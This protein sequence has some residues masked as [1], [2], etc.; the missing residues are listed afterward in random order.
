[1]SVSVSFQQ[2][3][4]DE[5][6]LLGDF[7]PIMKTLTAL[8]PL[9]SLSSSSALS[10]SV[11]SRVEEDDIPELGDFGGLWRYLEHSRVRS[12]SAPVQLPS[13]TFEVPEYLGDDLSTSS[14]RTKAEKKRAKR[15]RQKS[16]KPVPI[17]ADGPAVDSKDIAS[18]MDV[19]EES[20]YEFDELMPSENE[21]KGEQI[22]S[23]YTTSAPVDVPTPKKER[24]AVRFASAPPTPSRRCD[25]EKQCIPTSVQR[26]RTAMNAYQRH[27]LLNEKLA[28]M[29]PEESASILHAAQVPSDDSGF[30]SSPETS[31][32]RII[33]PYTGKPKRIYTPPKAKPIHIFI[34][35]SNIVLGFINKI[36]YE[37]AYQYLRGHGPPRMDFGAFSQ[38]LERSRP[39]ARKIL[40][41]SAP[42]LQPLTEA[43]ALGYEVSVLERVVKPQPSVHSDSDGGPIVVK[44]Y[45]KN[46]G[47]SYVDPKPKKGEQGVDELLH[48]KMLESIV[49]YEPATMV[50]GT[51]DGNTAEFSN[52]G[53]FRCVER[54]LQRGWKVELVCFKRPMSRIWEDKKFR[55]EWAGRF[56][57]VFL[58]E[59]TEC[60]T[61]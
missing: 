28:L 58:D 15:L 24:L 41:G 33:S 22:M 4:S 21:V 7:T 40:V 18:D 56:R 29:F 36:K 59:F 46:G 32:P 38:I 3:T 31:H 52:G 19:D 50:V 47:K 39:G 8:A 48:L 27:R 60:L 37:K 14:L 53:F 57:V 6:A 5:A 16:R 35:N 42:L 51:G 11:T 1:M 9:S 10:P 49:D 30:A 12:E 55:A 20:E 2:H 25:A 23:S 45:G 54:A 17:T 26:S 43:E 34:D 61:L 13:F 44:T